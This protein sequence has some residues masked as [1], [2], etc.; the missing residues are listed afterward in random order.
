[1][2]KCHNIISWAM[3]DHS[4]ANSLHIFFPLSLCLVGRKKKI[5]WK[6]KGNGEGIENENGGK[7]VFFFIGIWYEQKERKRI[8]VHF[9]GIRI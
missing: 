7:E 1:M 4:H 9:F 3:I 2:Q 6:F 5:G 8:Y